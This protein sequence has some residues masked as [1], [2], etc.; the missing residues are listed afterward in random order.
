MSQSELL[1]RLELDSGAEEVF[2]WHSRP[3][4]FERLSPPWEQVTL[5]GPAAQLTPGSR[6]TMRV[7]IGPFKMNWVAEIASVDDGRQFQDIQ[8]RGPFSKWEH[9]HSMLPAGS[10][11]CVL[12]DK[13]QYKLPL[14]P[15][16][17]AVAG[18]FVRKNL[19]RLFA[20]RHRITT[21]DL[22]RH[23]A[24]KAVS[25]MDILITGSN[26]LV[27]RT[28]IPFLTTGGHKVRRL[29]RSKP[30]GTDEFQW[31]PQS[32]QVDPAALD[33]VDAVIHLAGEGIAD[34]RWSPAQ[35][36][37]IR[38]SRVEGTRHLVAAINKSSHKPKTFISASAIGI[39]GE[40]G[41]D[42]LDE[43]SSPGTGFLA[44]VCKE[45][46]AESNQIEAVRSVQMRFGVILAAGGGALAKMLLPFKLGAGGKLGDGKQW[47]SWVALD[48]VIGAIHHALITDEISG[49]V[50]VVAPQPV[51]NDEY[52]RTLGSVLNR[53]TILPMPG[54]AARLAFGE[55]ADALLL[56]SQ[57][58][59]PTRLEAAQFKFHY[60]DLESAL[61]HQLG[62]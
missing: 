42:V 17:S 37:R 2:L 53:P 47:M 22:K 11:G 45:W 12:E 4:A 54:F 55:M 20:Y 7:P 28:L 31:D 10:G 21:Q 14:G 27:G 38:K 44:D 49:P 51:R 33:G 57:R 25:P 8:I 13:V 6:Q 59:L 61:R 23:S 9:T 32:G 18:A 1:H 29:V 26:G 60:P 15:L 30:S 24:T 19:A 40:G 3:G 52:T 39:Y 58:V 34:R 35:K 50:N 46:E 16:G 41:N 5:D 48:D 62:R 43:N 36:E 56:S